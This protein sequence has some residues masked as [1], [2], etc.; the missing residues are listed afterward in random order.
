MHAQ[1]V[2]SALVERAAGDAL[3]AGVSDLYVHVAST[4]AGGQQLYVQRCGFGMERR[5][6]EAV[7]RGLGRPPRLLLHREIAKEIAKATETCG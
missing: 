1:G 5:E 7:A 6:L 2:A 3:S 4:N